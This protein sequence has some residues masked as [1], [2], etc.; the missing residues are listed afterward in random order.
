M[1]P[2]QILRPINGV[3]CCHRCK[4][5]VSAAAR[6]YLSYCCS[7]PSGN[8][9][10]QLVTKLSNISRSFLSLCPSRSNPLDHAP[11]QDSRSL[12]YRC[13][14]EKIRQEGERGKRKKSHAQK[15]S[16]SPFTSEKHLFPSLSLL[17]PL[18]PCWQ[19]TGLVVVG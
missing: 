19:S 14:A 9:H 4:L 3:C 15:L 13:K 7:L 12:T 18:E 8:T 17:W 10:T 5:S 11:C 1:W 6:S 16:S 2:A